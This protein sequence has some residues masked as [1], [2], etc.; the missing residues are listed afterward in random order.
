MNRFLLYSLL[1]IFLLASAQA[2]TNLSGAWILTEQFPN[3][4]HTHRMTLEFNGEKL[5][6]QSGV[7]KIEGTLIN[8]AITMK[9]ISPNG[10]SESIFTGKVQDGIFKG[11][12]DWGGIKL[13]WSAR[14]PAT[15]PAAPQTHTFTPTEFHR[16]FSHAIPPVLHIFPGDTVKTKSVDAGGNDENSARRSL[17]GNPLTGPFFIEGA[18]PG[19]TL[20]IKLNRVRTN[21]DWAMSGQGVVSNALA[22]GYLMN[23]KRANNFSSRWKIDTAKGIAFLD[24]PT[25][26]LK[27]FTVPLQPMM[28]CIGVAPPGRDVVRT[29]DSGVFGGNMDYNQLREGTTIY[30][31]VFQDG[32]LLFMGDGHAAQGDG[33]LTGDALET[34]MDFEFTV[35]V[36]PEKSISTPRAENND[37]VM[38]IGIGGSLDQALQRATSEMARWLENDYKLNSTEAAMVLG[39]AVKYD[40]ADLVGT[41]V[42][43][44]AKIPK[45]VLAQLKRQ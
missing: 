45:T 35:D 22:P 29:G 7:D 5:T 24:K 41:Q 9:W 10:Q 34:S 3:D 30:L 2:Q 26:P 16:T 32:A 42:S 19:D 15:K 12:G 13:Q 17:G 4:T 33:E 36:I 40:V 37:Y 27:T 6:G 18:V 1:L 23:Q 39:F 28:G 8:G 21:R 11:E 20:V 44:V 14:R 25:D 38:A 31:P 43:I